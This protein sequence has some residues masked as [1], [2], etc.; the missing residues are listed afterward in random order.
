[1]QQ[2]TPNPVMQATYSV[3]ITM[4]KKKNSLWD[5][6]ISMEL[7]CAQCILNHRQQFFLE[8]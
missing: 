5:E 6:I 2:Y 3:I 4:K 8:N 1:M 7:I